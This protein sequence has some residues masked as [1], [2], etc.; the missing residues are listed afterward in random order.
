M[1]DKKVL[2]LSITRDRAPIVSK[3]TECLFGEIELVSDFTFDVLVYE[4]DSKDGTAEAFA[5][6][7]KNSPSNVA[8]A[9]VVSETLETEA[10][11]SVASKDRID[12]IANARNRALES[13]GDLSQY[14]LVVWVDSDYLLHGGSLAALIDEVSADQFDILSAYSLHADVQRPQGELFDKWA[15]RAQKEDYWW[16]CTPIEIMPAVVELYSTFNG[17]AAFNAQGFIDGARFSSESES[18]KV[19]GTG[20]DVEWVGLC[21]QFRA[22]GFGRIAM[23]VNCKVYHFMN[24]SNIV[25]ANLEMLKS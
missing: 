4:N 5:S 14:S 24:A 21:E 8:S 22:L 16:N 1:S 25:N 11:G 17:L 13:A 7:L 3:F 6:S 12:Q 23:D 15:T 2:I 9:K 20:Y 19:N 10:F 18:S